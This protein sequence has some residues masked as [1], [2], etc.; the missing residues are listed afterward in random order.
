MEI[1]FIDAALGKVAAWNIT[2]NEK[3]SS[4]N[5]K[6]GRMSIYSNCKG[7][8]MVAGYTQSIFGQKIRTDMACPKYSGR[9]EI[10]I[11]KCYFCNGKGYIKVQKDIEIKIPAGISDGQQICLAGKGGVG[12]NGEEN[13]DL[14]L[15]ISI[16]P[17]DF[18]E[19]KGDDIHVTMS[20]SVIGLMMGTDIKV[21]TIYGDII[22]K[23]PSGMQPTQIFKINEKGI[24][25]V[26]NTYT[27]GNQ[28]V[29][30]DVKVPKK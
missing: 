15:E 19:R 11:E 10:V 26:N 29:H 12:Y 16:K 27:I 17:H 18:F 24:R 25:N 13:G 23:I 1:S 7:S 22:L 6:G 3:C 5:G 8:G 30:L 21:P 14:Y 4:C 28:Y 9:G 20:V 2:Y